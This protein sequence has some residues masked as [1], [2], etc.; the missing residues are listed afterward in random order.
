MRGSAC[1]HFGIIIGGYG[2]RHIAIKIGCS[3]MFMACHMVCAAWKLPDISLP[4]YTYTLLPRSIQLNAPSIWNSCQHRHDL[5]AVS[6]V[7]DGAVAS[8]LPLQNPLS[9]SSPSFLIGTIMPLFHIRVMRSH[10]V[11]LSVLFRR[12]RF[13][14]LWLWSVSISSICSSTPTRTGLTTPAAG[15]I[16]LRIM[17]FCTGLCRSASCA[18][19]G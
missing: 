3:L 2:W 8:N 9:T 7:H 14:N 5:Q 10:L 12:I 16:L 6:R 1:H 18:L 11:A 4:S 13:M 19:T 15:V 17:T